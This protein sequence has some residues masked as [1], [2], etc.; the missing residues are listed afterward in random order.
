MERAIGHALTNSP[1]ARIA[2]RRKVRGRIGVELAK[3]RLS[4]R[5]MSS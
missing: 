2:Q 3:W 4:P 1:D 5:R